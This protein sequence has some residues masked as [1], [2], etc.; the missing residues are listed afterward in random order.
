MTYLPPRKMTAG[1]CCVAATCHGRTGWVQCTDGKAD[2]PNCVPVI[3]VQPPLG[4]CD[5][6][7]PMWFPHVVPVVYA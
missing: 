2:E 5:R 1:A 4:D 6:R 3:V 7:I